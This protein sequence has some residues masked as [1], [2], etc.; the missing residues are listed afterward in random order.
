MKFETFKAPENRFRDI[1]I[2]KLNLRVMYDA[3]KKKR[4]THQHPKQHSNI[5]F[6]FNKPSD[7]INFR[8]LKHP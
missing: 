1:K 4:F 5:C 8:K 7:S 6:F 2:E 3:V